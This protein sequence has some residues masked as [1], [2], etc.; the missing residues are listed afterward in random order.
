MPD[1]SAPEGYAWG[2]R[3]KAKKLHLIPFTGDTKPSNLVTAPGGYDDRITAKCGES[4]WSFEVDSWM[5]SEFLKCDAC[6][7]AKDAA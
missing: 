4:Q 5:T 7:A 3:S 1:E 6:V 2:K